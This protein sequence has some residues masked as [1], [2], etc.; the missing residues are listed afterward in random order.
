MNPWSGNLQI[1]SCSV[2]SLPYI[3]SFAVQKRLSMI[4]S[5]VFNFAF[6]ACA[7]YM[8]LLCQFLGVLLIPFVPETSQ[9]NDKF[10]PLTHLEL[11]FAYG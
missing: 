11:I 2:E 1:F 7:L 3:I 10:G 8:S 4:Q 9:S 5:H 6:V